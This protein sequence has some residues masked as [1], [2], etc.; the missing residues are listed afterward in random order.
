MPYTIRVAIDLDLPNLMDI[1]NAY[2]NEADRWNGLDFNE[3][4]VM[5]YI[6]FAIEDRSHNIFIAV[7]E[8]TKE[9]VGFFWGCITGQ[10]WSNDPIGQE[11]FL[12]V[13]NKARGK[14]IGKSLVK[15]FIKWCKVSGC[16][17]I[18][19]GAHSGIDNDKPAVSLYE[20]LGFKVGGYNFNLKL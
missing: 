12:Y 19:C 2:I 5:K 9:I 14:E 15:A 3:D 20:S 7:D 4:K 8:T 6:M 11:M 1:A 13:S 10:V 17:S 18:H 16:K